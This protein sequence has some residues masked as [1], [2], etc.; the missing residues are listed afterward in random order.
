LLAALI[1][2]TGAFAGMGGAL[3]GA[4]RMAVAGGAAGGLAGAGALAVP[5]VAGNRN[6]AWHEG[7][8]SVEPPRTVSGTRTVTEHFGH[9]SCIG[10][11]RSG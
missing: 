4:E 6:R 11:A 10:M 1:G 2:L 7:H 5:F 9:R 8:F 3:A